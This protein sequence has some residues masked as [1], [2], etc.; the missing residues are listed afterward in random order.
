MSDGTARQAIPRRGARSV[1]SGCGGDGVERSVTARYSC[2][3][4]G[5]PWPGEGNIAADPL[6]CGLGPRAEIHVDGSRSTPG[7][8]GP[9]REHR[10]RPERRGRGDHRRG[11]PRRSTDRSAHPRHHRASR[12]ARRCRRLRRRRARDREVSPGREHRQWRGLPRRV[13]AHHRLDHLAELRREA[14]WRSALQGRRRAGGD[15]V[16]TF[17]FLFLSAAAPP[18]P[19]PGECG[20]DPTPDALGCAMSAACE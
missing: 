16:A 11:E 4:A 1:A 14:R 5:A 9:R 15:A 20:R 10:R 6:L 19:G 7:D 13:A 3:E 18:P 8:P 2:I 17:G 12:Q